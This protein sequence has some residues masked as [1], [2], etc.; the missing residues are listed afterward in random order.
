MAHDES[1]LNMLILLQIE[2]LHLSIIINCIILLK[3]L[4]PINENEKT[5]V[6]I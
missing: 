4:T 5:I 3:K 6:L 2:Y 1:H